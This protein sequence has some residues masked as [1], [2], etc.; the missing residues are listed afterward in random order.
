[1]AFNDSRDSHR[2]RFYSPGVP[3]G[4]TTRSVPRAGVYRSLSRPEGAALP[5]YITR[6]FNPLGAYRAR[7]NALWP[8]YGAGK[9]R[10]IQ[11]VSARVSAA[12]RESRSPLQAIRR[13]TWGLLGSLRVP[14]PDKV[15]FCVRRKVRRGVLFAMDVAGRRGLG[16]G[17]VTRTPDS[18]WS[19]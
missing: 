12:V 17:G 6:L 18:A 5:D 10:R 3:T 9:P 1:M 8:G 2:E 14:V 4:G 19:C 7:V 15:R 13:S 11:P 16:R